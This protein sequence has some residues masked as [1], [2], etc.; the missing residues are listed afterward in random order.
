MRTGDFALMFSALANC[1]VE[2]VAVFERDVLGEAEVHD[3]DAIDQPSTTDREAR[4]GCRAAAAPTTGHARRGGATS[5]RRL[6]PLVPFAHVLACVEMPSAWSV[7]AG[8]VSP[9]M[10]WLA[11][12]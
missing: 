1:R 9:N 6:I 11:A 2:A 8:Y 10:F 7:L 12:R 5:A 4:P 3:R